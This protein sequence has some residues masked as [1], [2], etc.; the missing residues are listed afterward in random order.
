MRKRKFS[1]QPYFGGTGTYTVCVTIRRT[2][3]LRIVNAR[4]PLTAN[5][6]VRDKV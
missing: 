3:L 4:A 5:V 6:A 2:F 1:F